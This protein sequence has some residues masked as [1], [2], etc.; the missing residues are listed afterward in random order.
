[1]MILITK[2]QLLQSLGEGKYTLNNKSTQITLSIVKKALYLALHAVNALEGI[3][4]YVSFACT[5]A[6]SEQKKIEGCGKLIKLI[7]RDEALHLTSTQHI[8]NFIHKGQDGD[9]SLTNIARESQI[10]AYKIFIT[11]I[12]QEKAWANY[13]FQ[14]GS[15]LG[16]NTQILCQYIDFIAKERMDAVGLKYKNSNI[17][18]SNPIPW[19]NSYLCSDHVQV[20]PQETEISSYL[21]GQIE[22]NIDKNAF[23]DFDL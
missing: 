6:F 16:L 2:T 3:R 12:E 20:A 15:I 19:I 17:P 14:K 5:F 21:V 7:A 22:S 11:A 1:M 8:L 13:L 10:E 4:F 9:L 23:L 18:K